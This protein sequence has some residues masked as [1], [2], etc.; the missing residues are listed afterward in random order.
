MT[1]HNT[2]N[3]FGH[4]ETDEMNVGHVIRVA[5]ESGADNEFDYIV[6]DKFWPVQI[7]RRVE[8]PF[9]RSNKLQKAFCVDILSPAETQRDRGLKP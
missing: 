6:P 4:D 7:G 8:V 9:G 2:P 1:K 3:L 5:F